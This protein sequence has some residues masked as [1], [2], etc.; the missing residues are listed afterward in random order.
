MSCIHVNS[1][2]AVPPYVKPASVAAQSGVALVVCLILLA[3]VSLMG[4]AGMQLSTT[5]YKMAT[6]TQD[7]ATSLAAAEAAISIVETNLAT[8][9]PDRENLLS[10]CSG[11]ECFNASCTNGLC[12]DGLHTSVMTEWDCEVGTS[13]KTSK[14]REFWSDSVLKVWDTATRHKTISVTRLNTDVRY[15]VE[16][17]CYV[18]KD[19]V[20]VFSGAS[21]SLKN[22]GA[23]LYRITALAQGNGG[24]GRV[25]LQTTYKVT[26]GQ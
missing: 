10:T 17:L 24:K 18:Q 14:R 26:A 11:S 19:A 7:R 4:V 21:V 12:F 16:F 23:P 15:I 25:V 13:A 22:N 20:T 8:D 6:A 2:K 1:P 3:L 9:P 5:E